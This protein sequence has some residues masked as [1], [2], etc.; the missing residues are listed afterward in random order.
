MEVET[1]LV[2]L[3]LFSQFSGEDYGEIRY[4]KMLC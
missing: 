2:S 1:L 4:L 3:F